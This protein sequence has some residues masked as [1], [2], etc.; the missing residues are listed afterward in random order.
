ME[1]C[2]APLPPSGEKRELEPDTYLESLETDNGS[3]T[4]DEHD[5]AAARTA[6]EHPSAPAAA[7]TASQHPPA[8]TAARTAS[9]HLPA[10]TA[11]RTATA[12]PPAPTTEEPPT[13][14]HYQ[15]S[16]PDGSPFDTI[17]SAFV[18]TASLEV[19]PD[20]PKTT[21]EALDGPQRK[22]WLRAMHEEFK[23]HIRFGTFRE[24][25]KLP[26]NARVLPTRWAFKIK[27]DE[28]GTIARYK[29]RWV[30]KGFLQ[31]DGIDYEET[32]AAVMQIQT[33]RAIM[34]YA[35]EHDLELTHL[36]FT[37]AFLNGDID[38]EI[39]VL[40]PPGFNANSK[41]ARLLKG[42]YGTK[43]GGR[44]WSD[45]LK[46]R[47]LELGLTQC[48]T[49]ECLFYKIDNDNK[50]VVVGVYVDDCEVAAAAKSKDQL[51]KDL[52][53][54]FIINDLG[55]VRHMLGMKV[56]QDRTKGTIHLSQPGL[57]DKLVSTSGL[58]DSTPRDI[59]MAPN[60]DLGDLHDERTPE[61]KERL[62]QIP[63]RTTVGMMLYLAL[64]SRPDIA[65]AVTKLS[66]YCSNPGL[67]HWNAA[68]QVIRYLKG[69][70]GHGIL[71]RKSGSMTM[72]GHTDADYAG[73]QSD[74][75]SISGHAITIGSAPISWKVAKQKCVALSTMESELIAL[76]LTI[77]EALF[78]RHLLTEIGVDATAPTLIKADNQASIAYAKNR[79][80]LGR[81]KHIQVRHCFVKDVLAKNQISLEYV[82]SND[83]VA[84]LFTKALPKPAFT[85]HRERL[86]IVP[87]P[88]HSARVRGV[89]EQGPA[90]FQRR[91]TKHAWNDSHRQA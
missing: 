56:D 5:A 51:V 6:T 83:N 87:P 53:A 86:S 39:Y 31:R 3:S 89:S 66:Q 10:P 90:Q 36:D 91:A 16:S 35:L 72:I 48:K 46:A 70:K 81:A 15:D 64:G 57:I 63:Y 24:C 13:P 17:L 77:T 67:A 1:P 22:Q 8:T 68:K 20:E 79:G 58:S 69:T 80:S 43:Q 12:H 37:T 65:F 55:P 41:Y 47:L 76:S 34:V 52:S 33:S 78:W 19:E 38:K 54:N 11:A 75:K 71:Y 59:P 2:T 82:A 23:Q 14:P 9:T 50:P 29:A 42:L 28:D 85:R 60:L 26:L 4:S 49:D 7:R 40:L 88:I 61:E 30:A 45:K 73:D 32:Y 84:D 25:K 62:L 44:L 74:R 21:Q 18:A 27:R